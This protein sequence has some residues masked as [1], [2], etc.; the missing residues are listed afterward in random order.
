MATII[1]Q[2]GRPSNI[3][4][5]IEN[6]LVAISEN[7]QLQQKEQRLVASGTSLRSHIVTIKKQPDE[8]EYQASSY[9]IF[10]MKGQ[11]RK[12]GEFPPTKKT[13]AWINARGIRP[14]FGTTLKQLIFLIGRKIARLGTSIFEGKK[15]I[16]L[17]IAVNL[18]L[19]KFLN[20]VGD[21]MANQVA[22]RVVE[23][24]SKI[25]G[26]TVK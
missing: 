1:R 10:L 17:D 22:D 23:S 3:G 25:P 24:F 11:G 7:I 6:Y 4:K 13:E 8:G 12:P 16:D 15:G 5:A 2:V 26:A 9:Y 14:D 18:P 21:V 19:N 20:E